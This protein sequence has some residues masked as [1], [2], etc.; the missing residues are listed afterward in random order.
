MAVLFEAAVV[1]LGAEA[2]D[3]DGG[4]LG[5]PEGVEAGGFVVRSGIGA[6]VR[7]PELPVHLELVGH[8]VVELL[9]GFGDGVF[10]DGGGVVFGA[11][12]VDV[13][14]LVGRGFGEVDG[15]D[16]GGGDAGVSAD[17]GELA[18]DRDH[19]GREGV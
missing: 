3:F 2:E 17:G 16:A 5:L 19:R 15:V 4:G 10:D 14:A 12:V 8:V 18:H 11:V 1:E 9:G 13:D 6:D 7:G